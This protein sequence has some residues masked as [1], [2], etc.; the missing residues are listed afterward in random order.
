MSFY[1]EF[2]TLQAIEDKLDADIARIREKMREVK[3][4]PRYEDNESERKYQL[5]LLEK[6][7]EETL[8]KAED[9]F[10][11]ELK[12]IELHLAEQAF[13]MPNVSAEELEKAQELA[14][15]V[16]FQ[17][18]TSPNLDDALA[19]LKIRVKTMTDAEKQAV[20]MAIATIDLGEN[21]QFQEILKELDDTFHMRSIKKQLE[22]L[23]RIKEG[24]NSLRLKY[25]VMDKA[26]KAAISQPAPF[27]GGG[28]DYEFY[29]KHLKGGRN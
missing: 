25:D 22:A 21:K 11:T 10:Q 29:E 20:K 6:E 16:K 4:H 9:E 24:G 7:Y 1:K 18:M 2:P 13:S 15:I 17:L 19:L 3:K 28:I 12:A 23:K 8:A 14:N 27:F 5:E 26:V